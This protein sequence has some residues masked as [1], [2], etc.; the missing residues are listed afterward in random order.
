MFLFTYLITAPITNEV[1]FALFLGLFGY[2]IAFTYYASGIIIGLIG[3]PLIGLF[4]MDKYIEPFVYD[5][6]SNLLSEHKHKTFITVLKEAKDSSLD[7]F[8]N[9]W[10]YILIGVGIAAVIHSY[11]PPGFIMKYVGFDNQFAVPIAVILVIFFYVNIAM[12]LPIILIFVNNGLPI[13]TVLAFTMA[14][15]ATSIPE[16]LIL[17]RALKLPLLITYMAVLLTGIIL[18]GYLLNFIFR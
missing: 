5:E 6:H 1:A 12:A 14:V 16:L 4:R 7:F 2:K 3:G 13:G 15:T 10:L 18:T 9:F 11:V 8:Q 17:K